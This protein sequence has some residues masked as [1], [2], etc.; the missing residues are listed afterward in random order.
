MK[1]VILSIVLY[2]KLKL[3]SFVLTIFINYYKLLYTINW[4]TIFRRP[5]LPHQVN[6]AY[7]QVFLSTDVSPTM[8]LQIMTHWRQMPH[9]SWSVSS[10]PAWCWGRASQSRCGRLQSPAAAL[11]RLDRFSESSAPILVD[12]CRA[13]LWSVARRLMHWFGS[14]VANNALH[15]A[16][17]RFPN[18]EFSTSLAGDLVYS[19]PCLAW[20]LWECRA[21]YTCCIAG[22]CSKWV[23]LC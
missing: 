10:I 4:L 2:D 3:G 20:D 14:C 22:L 18:V 8:I 16:S 7:W 11:H 13:W 9:H 17:R 1:F 21:H 23:R 12:Y 6:S 15:N 5:S 19:I